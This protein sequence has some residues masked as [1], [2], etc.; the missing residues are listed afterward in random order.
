MKKRNHKKHIK[1]LTS[2]DEKKII[3][4]TGIR[5]EVIQFYKSLMGLAVTSLP[6]VN[7]VIMKKG[8]MLTHQ[9]KKMLCA[10]VTEKEVVEGL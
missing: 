2:L 8:P 4:P 1:E 5:E 3:E 9:Q 10:E 7:R 6:V